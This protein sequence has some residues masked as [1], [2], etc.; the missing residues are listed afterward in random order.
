MPIHLFCCDNCGFWQP[1][2]R[3]PLECPV[4]TD[5]RHSLPTDGYR[6]L[7]PEQMAERTR[8]IW[9]QPADWLIVFRNDPAFGIGP[10]GYLILHPA[11]NIAWESPAW[12]SP[13]ALDRIEELGGVRFLAASHPHAYGALWQLA[14]RFHPEATAIQ[15]TDLAWT[16][17]LQVNWPWDERLE[18]HPG[19]V[20]LHT[21]GHFPGHAVLHHAPERTL[22]AG[23]AMKFHADTDPPG[24][25]CHKG[26]NRRIPLSHAEVRRYR[27]TIGALEFEGVWTSFEWG[28]ADRQDVVRLYDAQLAGRP[29]V[30]PI[31]FG[32]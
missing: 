8:C 3:E 26:F 13:E 4:C 1:H 11:G 5:V 17:T 14:E 21:G 30:E 22:F 6:F 9:E 29:F 31:P 12:Y 16:R 10:N 20:L 15:V 23:D 28:S 18:L 25:S 7:T 24:I 19:I 27:D 2:F 32:E